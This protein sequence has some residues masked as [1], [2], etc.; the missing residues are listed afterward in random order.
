MR[1]VLAVMAAFALLGLSS[2]AQADVFN[3]GPGLVNLE[4]VSVGD[5]GNVG[6]TSG[7][8]LYGPERICGSVSYTYNIG[9]YEV[10]AAQYCDFLN[11]KAQTDPYGLY[12]TKM[13]D[14][15][16]G[17]KIQRNGA[18]GGYTYS[19]VA[20]WANKPVNFVSY[21]D[22]CRFANWLS[23][24]QGNCDTETGTYAL[25]DYNGT[26]GR[27]V[28]R[29]VEWKWAVTSEDEWY[30]AAYY[31]GDGAEV[32]YWDFPTQS[33]SINT[34]M[35]NYNLSVGSTTNVGSYLYTGAYGTFDQGGNVSEWNESL[36]WENEPDY[37][38]AARGVRG[39]SFYQSTGT[40]S[41]GCYHHFLRSWDR[42]GGNPTDEGFTTG[43]RVVQAVPEPM[44]VITLLGGLVP[45][46]FLRR[47]G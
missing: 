8:F 1:R 23:N 46:I 17:C 4:T 24:G 35:A 32:G 15:T 43:F 19:V 26:D 21:W 5:P 27:A 34:G 29:N 22:A 20:D 47:R 36:I 45:L 10:T 44:S 39:G 2:V 42:L 40:D 30:K 3:I 38:G 16:Y 33:D 25:R 11:H 12:N 28:K 9:K 13:W 31:K 7:R 6:E 37:Y 41:F 18:D 14:D